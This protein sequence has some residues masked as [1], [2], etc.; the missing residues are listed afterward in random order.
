MPFG[1]TVVL[2]Q[3]DLK[4]VVLRAVQKDVVLQLIHSKRMPALLCRLE[5]C[6]LRLSDNNSLDFVINRFFFMK[7]FK[8]NH[9]KAVT[10]CS[11]QFHFYLPST[12]LKKVMFLLE[13]ID[14]AATFL[15]TCSQGC[16]CQIFT[17]GSEFRLA[18]SNYS[19]HGGCQIGTVE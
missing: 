7:L 8:T 1:Q 17:G 14:R 6:P 9:L 10:Y 11:M 2:G 19:W 12:V 18:T 5:A 3:L 13:N 4:Q 15:Y 16:I